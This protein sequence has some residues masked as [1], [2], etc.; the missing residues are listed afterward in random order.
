MVLPSKND[1]KGDGEPHP[2]LTDRDHV[3][4]SRCGVQVALCDIQIL[5][6]EGV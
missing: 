3:K 2:A 6:I 4:V 5:F 1:G